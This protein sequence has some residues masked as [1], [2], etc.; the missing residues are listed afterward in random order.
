MSAP[1]ATG[2]AALLLGAA[3]Q[4][5]VSATP[6]ELRRAIYSSA[7]HNRDVD[8]IAQGNGQFNVEKAWSL[9]SRGV[10][11]SEDISVPAPVCTVVSEKLIT[12]TRA[13]ACST[14]A[15]RA[16]AARAS[17]SPVRTTSP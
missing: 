9:L 4:A 8:A 17:A 16:A 14:A 5:G 11:T 2:A 13:T 15:R 1:Q 12:P 10:R 3:K 6:A 7:D